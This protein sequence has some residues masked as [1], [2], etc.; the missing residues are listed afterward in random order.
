MAVAGL[1]YQTSVLCIALLLSGKVF[2]AEE[3]GPILPH[4]IWTNTS[5][6]PGDPVIFEHG[7]ANDRLPQK[8]I[9]RLTGDFCDVELRVNDQFVGSVEAFDPVAEFDILPFL[10]LDSNTVHLVAYPVEGPSAV[11]AT[12]TTNWGDVDGVMETNTHWSRNATPRGIITPER[13]GDNRLRDVAPSAEYNQWKEA[14]ADATAFQLSDLPDGFEATPVKFA[15]EEEDSWVSLVV[16]PEGRLIVGMEKQGLLR[17][18]LS[19]DKVRE[20]EVI[21]EDL[22]EC[23]GLAFHEG[24]LYANANDSKALYRLRDTTGD[25][26]FDEVTLI[27]ETVGSVGHG[28]NDL[29]LAPDWTIHAIHGDSV[30]VPQGSLLETAAESPASKPLGHWLSLGRDNDEWII[31]ARGL[32]NPYGLDFDRF[33]EA[34]TYDADNEG[35]VGLPF[36]IPSRINHLV[37]GANYGWQ[38]RPGNTRSLPVYAPDSVPT[39]FDVGRGSPTSVKFGYRSAFP[40]A[41]RDALFAL[42]WAYGRILAVH[43][44]PRGA[45]YYASGSEFLSGR[46]L[47]V[48]DLDFTPDGTM[49]F[50]TGGRRTRSALFRLRYTGAPEAESHPSRHA[51]DREFFSL[52]RREIRKRLEADNSPLSSSDDCWKFL[53]SAD[54]WLRNAAR[55]RLEKR[56]LAEWRGLVSLPGTNTGKL[57]ARLALVRQGEA[58][59]RENALSTALTLPPEN[60]RRTEKL[61]LLRI[62]ELAGP[63]TV[64]A[65]NRELLLTRITDWIETPEAPVTRE[66]MRVM[67]LFDHPE[68]PALATA[69]LD[70]SATQEDRL[71]YLERLSEMKRGWSHES[72]ILFFKTLAMA[73]STSQG[74][75][76]MPPFFDAIAERAL[77]ALPEAD[78]PEFA[79][80]LEQK[81]EPAPTGDTTPRA[82]VRN[83]T[84]DDFDS[85]AF[86]T[87]I[88]PGEPQGLA[89]YRA[90]LCHHCHTF[91]TEGIPIGPDL[92]RVGSRFSAVDLARA[93]LEPSE[94][95]SEVYRNLEV[96]RKDGSRVIGRLVRDDFRESTLHFSINPF[97]PGEQISVAKSDIVS[98]KESE[99]SPMPP[100]L[101][102]TFTR[103]EAIAL[104]Q[105]LLRGPE[106]P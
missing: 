36:Y 105:W 74:D 84:P 46:P 60:W 75:R 95:I 63:G 9:V 31:H 14:L 21:N 67:A 86:T 11:A 35:D 70:L 94:V 106:T 42:D 72:R 58:K 8:A 97:H 66:V 92:T 80:L 17:F 73:R 82:F 33:G 65:G 69:L 50:T 99:V 83:W 23:R 68:G 2:A 87:L 62:A 20:V 32:R 52:G 49:Y 76:F 39:T 96:E 57:T 27:R 47:N 3:A 104:M 54:P 28:R 48:T 18:T 71:F 13:W 12:L 85:H 64:S 26:Q 19:G 51:A 78:R 79:A 103:E 91:G 38:Q 24:A 4:W 53:G 89:L 101:L 61:T 100:N 44:T 55:V 16:D 10:R 59:D 93:I 102:S 7:F 45:S 15:T 34:F 29:A 81:A 88:P 37:R 56:P 22:E 43:L 40:G 90:G 98:M 77:N 1:N 25:D 41:W 6:P 5:P 30:E